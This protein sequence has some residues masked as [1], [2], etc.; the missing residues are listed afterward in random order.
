MKIYYD[1]QYVLK[2]YIRYVTHACAKV[3]YLEQHSCVLILKNIPQ[4]NDIMRNIYTTL[5]II[6]KSITFLNHAR[7]HSWL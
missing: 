7:A 5:I 6:S 4:P 3:L 1:V 2:R